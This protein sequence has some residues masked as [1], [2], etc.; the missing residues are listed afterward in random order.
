MRGGLVSFFIVIAVTLGLEASRAEAAAQSRVQPKRSRA[1]KRR[2]P[3]PKV[4]APKPEAIPVVSRS[5]EATP[6]SREAS[7][8]STEAL[9]QLGLAETERLHAIALEVPHHFER[10]AARERVTQLL[11]FWREAYGVVSEWRGDRVLMHGSV[12]GVSI[13]ALFDVADG[14]VFAVARD[15]GWFWRARAHAYVEWMLRKYLHPTYQ[16]PRDGW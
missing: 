4:V 15:P 1:A 12:R 9:G 2:A 5:V 8:G 10:R 3:P 13:D 16:E 7:V 14:S 11:Q 6:S